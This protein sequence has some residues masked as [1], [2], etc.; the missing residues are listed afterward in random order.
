MYL[1]QMIETIDYE[2]AYTTCIVC[3]EYKEKLD[4]LAITLKHNLLHIHERMTIFRNYLYI[5]TG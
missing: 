5:C 4:I 1:L 2:G 3:S